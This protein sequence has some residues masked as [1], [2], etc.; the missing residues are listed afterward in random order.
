MLK[1]NLRYIEVSHNQTPVHR[2][3]VRRANHYTIASSDQLN[4]LESKGNT[5]YYS[6]ISFLYIIDLLFFFTQFHSGHLTK[7]FFFII[8]IMKMRFQRFVTINLLWCLLVTF[9]VTQRNCTVISVIAQKCFLDPPIFLHRLRPNE[10]IKHWIHL[11]CS[12]VSLHFHYSTSVEIHSK[13][14]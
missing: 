14:F 1:Q 2:V 11:V 7:M 6:V 13:T 3:A 9:K 5:K 10:L 8:S 12:M 4:I